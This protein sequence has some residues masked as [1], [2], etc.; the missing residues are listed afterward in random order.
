VVTVSS[1]GK[2]ALVA[3]MSAFASAAV[4][5]GLTPQPLRLA[6]LSAAAAPGAPG[7]GLA[8]PKAKDG[9]FW[10]VAHIN[11]AAVRVLVDTGATAVALTPADATRLGFRP[12]DLKYAYRVTTAAGGTRAAAVK[13]SS[14]SVGGA[15]LA[16]V[17]ALV[18]EQGLDT[19]LLGM[20]Y[21]GRLS[22]FTATPQALTLEL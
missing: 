8:I 6:K 2:L 18:V 1:L 4:L 3:A 15:R 9:H 19:S 7:G 11:G 22:R 21:L 12:Q 20:S 13:L 5:A 10:A 14:V 17:D 16:E